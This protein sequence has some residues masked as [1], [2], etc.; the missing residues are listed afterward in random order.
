M[1]SA[2]SKCDPPQVMVAQIG[3]RHH[4]AIPRMLEKRGHL[5]AFHTDANA[6]V[7]LGWVLALLPGLKSKGSL[8]NLSQRRPQG[9]PLSKIKHTDALL[10]RRIVGNL[11][12]AQPYEGY[13]ADDHL[14]DEIIASR[15]F[16]KAN[17]LYA[18]QK[19]GTKMLQAAQAAGV[20]TVVDVFITPLAHHIVEQE[21]DQFP[22]IEAPMTD[23]SS[24]ELEDERTRREID[25]ADLLLC[26]GMN[27]V[28]GVA[29]FANAAGKDYAVVPYGCGVS[30]DG[31]KNKPVKGRVLFAGTADLRK[32]IHYL[33]MAAKALGNKNY[34]FRVAGN[35]TDAVRNHELTKH[36]NF[37]GRVPRAEMK[38]E[39]LK[40][41]VFVLPTLAE[42]CASVVHEAVMAGCPVITT[43]A[44]GT[45]VAHDRGGMIVP[46]RDPEA[47]AGAI[48][49]IVENRGRRDELAASCGPLA[50]ELSEDRWS[51]RLMAA[52]TDSSPQKIPADVNQ[53]QA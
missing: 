29:S 27:V 49:E 28:E 8:K 26:P 38:E 40:A 25:H 53:L 9:V 41:D 11:G 52:L 6:V 36:L 13:I 39:F 43:H 34:D 31:L 50:E 37:L 21:R 4:Y 22:D 12:L 14:F 46:E 16:G 2:D 1:P 45:L 42:G 47:L 18:M 7:G 20:R 5:A 33:G 32:G 51:E 30:F 35:V 3:A 48:A 19:H 23:R 10:K 15:G 17:M 24:F 44:S